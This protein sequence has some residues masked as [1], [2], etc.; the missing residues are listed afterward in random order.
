MHNPLSCLPAQHSFEGSI[1]LF[2]CTTFL[3][4]RTPHF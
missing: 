4:R 1:I 2:T 3:W